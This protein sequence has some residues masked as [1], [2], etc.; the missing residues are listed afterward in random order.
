MT[1]TL[2]PVFGNV[3]AQEQV[4]YQRVNEGRKSHQRSEGEKIKIEVRS[5]MILT[6]RLVIDL[7]TVFNVL[8]ESSDSILPYRI[9][10][11]AG[12]ITFV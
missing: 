12:Y 1:Q 3:I 10:P 4:V 8:V 11:L 6:K 9:L 2:E 7:P 5:M